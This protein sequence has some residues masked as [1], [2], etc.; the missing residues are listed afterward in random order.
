MFL[1]LGERK[2]KGGFLFMNRAQLKGHNW[3][4]SIFT[5]I[6]I[7]PGGKRNGSRAVSVEIVPLRLP[8]GL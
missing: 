8:L 2:E 6:F 3:P 7:H 4:S 5:L 1:S